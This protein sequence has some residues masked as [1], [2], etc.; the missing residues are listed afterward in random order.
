MCTKAIHSF[1]C[2]GFVT[3]SSWA[4]AGE[5]RASVRSHMDIGTAGALAAARLV[6]VLW[7]YHPHAWERLRQ[8][9]YQMMRRWI[10]VAGALL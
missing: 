8:P 4:A 2:L 9:G 3:W 10:V 1:A 5:A 7:N 6:E